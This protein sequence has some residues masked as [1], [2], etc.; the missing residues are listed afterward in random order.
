M[1]ALGVDHPVGSG[2]C[3][4]RPTAV[5]RSPSTPTSARR[6]GAPVPSTT[7]PPVITRSC[8]IEIPLVRRTH[9]TA[10]GRRLSGRA[11][12]GGRVRT[13]PQLDPS[14]RIAPDGDGHLRARA[15]VAGR[16]VHPGGRLADPARGW[17][18]TPLHTANLS[19]SW[20]RNKRWD[21]WA[22]LAGDLVVSVTYADVDYLGIAAVLV[23]RPGELDEPADGPAVTPVARGMDLPDRPVPGRWSSRVASCACEC[24]KSGRNGGPGGHRPTCVRVARIRWHTRPARD[25]QRRADP[26]AMSPSTS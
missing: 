17:S 24:A 13:P 4:P 9:S 5:M 16:T 18:R 11:M 21:Y 20:G 6:A 12:A 1:A 2:R 23:G 22:I 15:D 8:A 10:A 7:V 25:R 19:G 26:Q 14:T 3:P